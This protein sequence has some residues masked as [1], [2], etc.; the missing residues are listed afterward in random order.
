MFFAS[1]TFVI[2]HVLISLVGIATGL[3]VLY[4]MLK[5][6]RLRPLT[7]VF[8][9]FTLATSLTGFLFPI[10]GFTPAIALGV[11][12]CVI[13]AG[14][15]LSLYR[16]K[17]KGLFR[18]LYVG[19]AVAALW[20]NCFVLV[21]QSF[22]K[23]PALHALAPHGNEPPFAIVQGLVLIGFVYA[24]YRAVKRFRPVVGAVLSDI[25]SKAA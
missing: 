5:G 12:S 25:I 13:L 2:I 14:A 11:V 3:A 23:I 8:L 1:T 6:V 16:F 10:S 9:G 7:G 24:G 17:L 18:P 4:G 22:L 15:Y 19:C 21:V 20:L